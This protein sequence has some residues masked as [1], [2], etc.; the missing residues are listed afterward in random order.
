MG[1]DNEV[2]NFKA[3]LKNKEFEVINPLDACLNLQAKHA[4]V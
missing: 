3:Q 4:S 1:V 2:G